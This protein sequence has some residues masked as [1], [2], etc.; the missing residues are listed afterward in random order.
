MVSGDGKPVRSR[1]NPY[2]LADVVALA[3]ESNV[4]FAGQ[5]VGRNAA[6]I[7]MSYDDVCRCLSE[8]KENQ[9]RESLLYPGMQNQLDV[10][11]VKGYVCAGVQRD[12]YVKFKLMNSRLTLFLCSFHPEG[13]T[14]ED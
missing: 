11:V 9:F 6:E 5:R 2:V 1:N 13:W 8:L 10:Y 14:N 3:K 7:G 12:L 4:H